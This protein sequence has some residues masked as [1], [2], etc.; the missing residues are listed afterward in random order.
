M[1]E[2]KV[3]GVALANNV[4]EDKEINTARSMVNIEHQRQNEMRTIQYQCDVVNV[5]RNYAWD[6]SYYL[7]MPS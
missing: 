1:D 6:T 5:N 4:Q 3:N 7:A 2:I